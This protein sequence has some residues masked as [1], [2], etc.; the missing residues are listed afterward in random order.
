MKRLAYVFLL[1]AGLVFLDLATKY[2]AETYISPSH[3]KEILPFLN[4]VNV[5]NEGAAFGLF[6]SF[7]NKFFIGASS[8]AIIFMVVFLVKGKEST[9]SLSLILSG[10]IG[11][12]ADR[13][14]FG[15]VRDFIDVYAGRYHW[16]A[17]N[18]AD[19]CLTVGLLLLLL[20]MKKRKT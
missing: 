12:M 6:K 20:P 16:P 1:V 3:P 5:R 13:L 17:F 19:S 15:Y 18:V 11:N 14:L 9:L 10:A 8:A 2:L 4:L 7:G